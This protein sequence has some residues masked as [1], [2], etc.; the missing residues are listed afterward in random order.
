VSAARPTVSLRYF[1]PQHAS[2]LVAP[3]A[4]DLPA[5]VSCARCG[6]ERVIH[7]ARITRDGGLSGCLGCGERELYARKDFPPALGLAIVV[8]AV[9]LVPVVPY[10]ASL[11][12]A[13]LLDAILYHFAPDVVVCYRCA[14]EHR[15]FLPRPRH[16]RFD[17]TIEERLRYG[18]R[19]VMGK[20][21]RPGGTADAPEPE[22]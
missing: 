9:C 17:R 14:S 22:H 8:L 18:E 4:K 15:R 1:C 2:T 10:Y 21:P 7:L 20:P 16:P 13:A 19:A 12:A 5:R 6:H 11:V 3:S